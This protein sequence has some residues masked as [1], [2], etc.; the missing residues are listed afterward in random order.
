M[1]P[2][3]TLQSL[4][5]RSLAVWVAGMTLSFCQIGLANRVS[6]SD[7]GLFYYVI[8]ETETGRI[9]S[10]AQMD[11][12][13]IESII[14]PPETHFSIYALFTANLG[15]AISE[16]TTPRNGLTGTIPD[17]YYYDIE[18]FDTDGDGLSD[19]REFIVGTNL[20]N[21]DTDGDGVNDGPE[22]QQGLNALDGFIVE[23]GIVGSS[24]VSDGTTICV[25]NNL[26]IVGQ[27]NRGIT[28]FNVTDSASPVRVAD[29]AIQGKISD[30]DCADRLVAVAAGSQ[31]LAVVD[32]SDPPAASIS[33]SLHFGSD[34]KTVVMNGDQAYVGLANG[35]LAWVDLQTG[36]ELAR[37]Q[38]SASSIADLGLG[39]NV[40]YAVA[41]TQFFTIDIKFGKFELV[42]TLALTGSAPVNATSRRLFVGDTFAL[43]NHN[44]GYI[45]V[46]I[47]DPM[48]PAVG[49]N[50][51]GSRTVP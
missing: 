4:L 30:V 42:H 21:P 34:V 12:G 39:M 13:G 28:V 22:V 2:I 1:K 9:T 35:S 26:A 23:T 25:S 17:L 20:F 10:Q 32:V 47:S 49:P 38:I 43:L 3:S 36:I 40:L 14:L 31:G 18:D 19:L 51:T 27:E 48:V 11:I 50:G 24:F 46:N 15:V 29:V 8:V 37:L 41:G 44:R 33:R 16:F 5:H 7:D 45:S 6:V